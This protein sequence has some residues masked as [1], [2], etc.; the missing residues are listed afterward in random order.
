MADIRGAAP[1]SPSGC[2]R[3]R[4]MD[5][6]QTLPS[7]LQYLLEYHSDSSLSPYQH[8]PSS[9]RVV[10]TLAGD[11]PVLASLVDATTEWG[12]LEPGATTRPSAEIE[13]EAGTTVDE[14]P[15]RQ[16]TPRAI[17]AGNDLDRGESVIS[18]GDD[19]SDDFEA[20][21]LNQG[22][23]APGCNLDN[24]S[25]DDIVVVRYRSGIDYS[26]QVGDHRIYRQVEVL[27]MPSGHH[28]SIPLTKEGGWEHLVHSATT[29]LMW[30]D[31]PHAVT[32]ESR[33][34]IR[35]EVKELIR[36]V[37]GAARSCT[38]SLWLRVPWPELTIPHVPDLLWRI[39]NDHGRELKT[40]FIDELQCDCY[41][42]GVMTVR[43][44]PFSHL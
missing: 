14:Y 43:T 19:G 18:F 29:L 20:Q 21:Y 44:S 27:G 1:H 11:P 34:Q 8:S 26:E 17:L 40:V 30:F 23:V 12:S 9:P 22:L 13:G 35:E 41:A 3:R 42:S 10:A 2:E 25:L 28:V 24:K 5:S 7:A 32:K 39:V 4:S 37:S 31:C 36:P 15:T 33:S 6:P 38:Q 16:N